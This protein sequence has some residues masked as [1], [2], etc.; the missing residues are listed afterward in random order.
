MSGAAMVLVVSTFVIDHARAQAGAA[1]TGTSGPKTAAE[2]FKNIQVLKDIPADDLIPAMQFITASLGKECEFCHV[3]GAFEKD[4]KKPK[5]TARKMMEMMFA[6]NKDNFEGHR[7]VTCYTCHQGNAHP[8]GIPVVMAAEMPE[9]HP[10][11]EEEHHAA[12]PPA[13]ELFDKYLKAVGGAAAVEKI[14]SR[15]MKGTITFGDRNVPIDIYSKDP[16]KR[17]S[18]THTPDGDSV[19]GFNGHEGWLGSPKGPMH[20]MHGP[21]IDGASIDADLHFAAHLKDLFSKAEVR[22]TEKIGDSDAYFVVGQRE[23]KTPLRL[24]FDEK[25]GLLVRLVRFG[26]T[27]L[28]RMPTQIDYADYRDAGGVR[29]PFRWTLARAGGRFTIQVSDVKENLP[30]DDSRFEKPAQEPKPVK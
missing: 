12:G 2:Q 6:I 25:S 26:E 24:Y 17:V 21:D 27:P 13:Q 10:A 30:V 1:Q 7:E 15:V 20:G 23:G 8:V 9:M 3:Q 19:T 14:N 4:D 29:I 16:D 11:D 22:G 28:G 18:I 5:Q